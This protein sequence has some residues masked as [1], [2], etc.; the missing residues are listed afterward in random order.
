ME[1][2]D[3]SNISSTHIVASM[4]RFRDGVPDRA[5]YRKYRIHGTENQNDFA[6]MAEVVRR[7][8]GRLLREASALDENAEFN[9]EPPGE[10]V[11]RV[12]ED[13][14]TTVIPDLI[15]VDGGR[16]QLSSA[17]KEL[18]R[19]GLHEAPVIGLAKEFEEI[20]RP[21]RPLPM[22][23]PEDSGALRLLQRIRDEAHRTAN[24]YHSLLLKRRISESFLDEIP[25]I[26]K[27]R[28]LAL[29]ERFGSVER[30]KK[31][32]AG[33]IAAVPGISPALAS[34]ILEHLGIR[35]GMAPGEDRSNPL[36]GH[37]APGTKPGPRLGL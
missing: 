22:K 28:K 37:P 1:C 10:A 26:S 16:G 30:L 14:Q 2:F 6:S 25:G 33:K 29:L 4:V 8:Y 9:Q 27:A 20:Y 34:V 12:A 17:C 24:G 7:R 21:G 36:A 11:A 35:Q 5:G 18:Q 15:I 23:L 3:I 19:L 13:T 32:P 31:S